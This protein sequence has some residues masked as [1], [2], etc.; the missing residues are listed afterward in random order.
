MS[1]L[2]RVFVASSGEKLRLAY[3]VQ[4]NLENE[5]EVTVWTQAFQIGRNVID[6]LERNL[7]RSDFG[8]FVFAPD[9]MVIIRNK[10]QQTVRDNVVLELGMF[11]GR[12]GKERSFIVRPKGT[13]MRLPT[14]LLGV[15]TSQYDSDRAG[16]EPR[17]ALGA[18]CAQI[19][20]AIKREYKKKTK[21][22]NALITEALE[23]ICRAM[24]VPV[25][26]EA[27]S[28]RA[29]IFRKEQ[30]WLVCRYFWDPVKSEEKVGKTRF[31]LDEDTAS[32][33]AVVRC[34]LDSA[35]QRRE[36][37]GSSVE[38]LPK[39]HKGVE[40]GVKPSLEFVLPATIFD[41]EDE[42]WGVVDFDASNETGQNLLKK[43]EAK[44]IILRLATHLSSILT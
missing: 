28:L 13:D 10:E 41:E 23:T 8:V 20:D 38:P 35:T 24:S 15:V 17:P 36:P 42:P 2:P 25:T 11:I 22:V 3:A 34:F 30:D 43:R 16:R 1:N 39:D 26:P 9:D 19:A 40:G 18:A 27:A 14:D 7:R 5:A 37:T 12:L 31:H 33:I 29:F 44:A 32:R 6:E 21:E 4:E